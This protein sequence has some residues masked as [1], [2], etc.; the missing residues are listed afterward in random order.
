MLT[1][2]DA[3]LTE[4]PGPLCCPVLRSPLPHMNGCWYPRRLSESGGGGMI[5]NISVS[6]FQLPEGVHASLLSF[7]II[8]IQE[9]CFFPYW[10][11][12]HNGSSSKSPPLLFTQSWHS[13]FSSLYSVL[14]K[15][16]KG[17]GFILYMGMES[18]HK[19]GG[20]F[21]KSLNIK[22][23]L[24]TAKICIA[25]FSVSRDYLSNKWMKWK[26]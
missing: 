18:Y 2:N 6:A 3:G 15:Q 24:S 4:L 5:T 21:K 1:E 23:Q 26:F 11:P 19:H 10:R 9:E 25:H 12:Q 13:N 17:Q 8:N 20:Q 16:K 22:K 14:K 7:Y